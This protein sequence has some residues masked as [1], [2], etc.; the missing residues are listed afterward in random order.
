MPPRDQMRSLGVGEELSEPG[1]KGCVVEHIVLASPDDHG[2]Q[3]GCCKLG[4]EPFEPVQGPRG[5]VERNPARPCP[6]QETSRRAGQRP[7]VCLLRAVTE[8]FSVN[9]GKVNA[10]SRERVVATEKVR[11]EQ[12]RMHHPPWKD[13]RVE[14]GRRQWP[15]PGTHDDESGYH[16]RDLRTRSQVLSGRPNRGRRVLPD[17]G[18]AAAAA[19]SNPRYD[20]QGCV[21]L[22]E[23]VFLRGQTRSCR[24]SQLCAPHVLE[25]QQTRGTE[26]PRSDCRAG[27]RD[28]RLG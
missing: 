18:R 1:R 25:D 26:S 13:A 28:R 2:R 3:A 11:T 9:N 23:S 24:G 5:C 15:G 12:R 10:T 16:S 7:F 19:L 21:P 17:G 27:Q 6:G 20:R 8:F 14:L 4:L 22:P